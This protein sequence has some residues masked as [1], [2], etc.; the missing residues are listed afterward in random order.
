MTLVAVAAVVAPVAIVGRW[1]RSEVIHTERFV[2]SVA[3][4]GEDRRFQDALVEVLAVR[5]VDEIDSIEPGIVSVD[6]AA[7]VL[8]RILR[9]PEFKEFWEGALR[10]AHPMMSHLLLG[11]DEGVIKAS[12]GTVRLDLGQLTRSVQ[13]ELAIDQAVADDPLLPVELAQV[14]LYHSRDLVEIQQWTRN[15]VTLTPWVEKFLVALMVGALVVA[16]D[17]RRTVARLAVSLFSAATVTAVALALVRTHYHA[18]LDSVLPPVVTERAYDLVVKSLEVCVRLWMVATALIA[19]MALVA[20]APR[21]SRS[22]HRRDLRLGP[23]FVG[24][25]LI[26]WWPTPTGTTLLGVSVLTGVTMLAIEMFTRTGGSNN[27]MSLT[28]DR[29]SP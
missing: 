7:D 1:I 13:R 16:R 26:G 29:G 9:S 11:E 22:G 18:R 2:A 23:L 8:K 21:G 5:I 6:D 17:R 4:L 24:G 14:T 10:A 12:A 3:P 25:L 28:D 19:V 20:S 15:V 27:V